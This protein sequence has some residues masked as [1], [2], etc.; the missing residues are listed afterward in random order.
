MQDTAAFATLIGLL[1]ATI[2]GGLVCQWVGQHARVAAPAIVLFASAGL[3]TLFPHV[4]SLSL[5]TGQRAVTIALIF[6]LFDGGMAI[7]WRDFRSVAVTVTWLGVAGT[8]LTAAGVAL[9]SH[10]VFGLAPRACLLLGAALSPTD[11]AVV[12]S[13]LGHRRFAGRSGVILEGESGAN[14][15]VG[16]TL[17]TALLASTGIGGWWSALHSAG[18]FALQ[19]SVGAAAG[20]LGAAA[21]HVARR[22]IRLPSAGLYA[23]GSLAGALLIYAITVVAHGSG[24]LAVLVAGILL[25]DTASPFKEEVAGFHTALAN[26]GELVAFTVLGLTVSLRGLAHENAWLIG[27][28]LGALLAFVVRPLIVTPMLLP[29][30]LTSGERAF[31]GVCGLKGAVPILLGSYLVTSH[32][33]A[34]VKLYNIIFVVVALSVVVQGSLTPWFA[35]R[36]QV[37]M[38]TVPAQPWAVRMRLRHP[39]IGVANYVVHP[40]AVADGA[41]VSELMALEQCW[42]GLVSRDGAVLPV[43]VATVLKAGDEVVAIVTDRLQDSA[44]LFRPAERADRH[45][46][47]RGGNG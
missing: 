42:I 27:L 22:R 43:T 41:T 40:G 37:P 24:F 11:P 5:L 9:L 32:V 46:N 12:F 28:A 44:T 13:V 2:V 25:G 20:I 26:L 6:V 38:A 21:L 17:M 34:A 16:I 47:A 36:L 4:S 30:Q 19:M 29:A 31:V 1:G 14:D 35:D 8:L 7:G 3:S 23:V 15:P 33:T 39:P 18:V 45:D 10:Y